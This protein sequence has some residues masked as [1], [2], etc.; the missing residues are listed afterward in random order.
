MAAL[1]GMVAFVTLLA[2]CGSHGSASPLGQVSQATLIAGSTEIGNA[3]I[4][5]FHALRV[6]AYYQ[7]KP[8][9]LV[10]AQ[11]PVIVRQGSCT[12]T[13]VGAVTDGVTVTAG[14]GAHAV[15]S[16]PAPD[17]GTYLA[18]TPSANLYVVI[19]AQRGDTSGHILACGNPL[20]GLRQY[21]GLFAPG[22]AASGIAQ[23]TALT[24]PVNATRLT[25]SL[26][27]ALSGE[28]TWA[29]HTA[30]CSGQVV[31]SGSLPAGQTHV[32]TE[33]FKTLSAGKWWLSVTDSGKTTC[34]QFTA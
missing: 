21:F 23:G 30:S 33:T 11:T 13:F 10:N 19:L 26:Q 32:T 2:A 16:A 27:H 29:I 25:F 18:V 31:A 9:P 24:D 5:P 34:S 28:G 4:T 1:T 6:V 22:Q 15:A 14:E 17:G 20:S 12:G 8:I 3:T 7:G